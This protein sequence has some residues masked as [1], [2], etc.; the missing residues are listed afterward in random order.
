MPELI[1]SPPFLI[2][3]AIFA[4]L[5]VIGIAKR[6]IRLL[7]WIAVIFVILVCFGITNQSDLFNWFENFFKIAK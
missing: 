1:S 7:I 6:A 3:V 5:L 2:I 4:I